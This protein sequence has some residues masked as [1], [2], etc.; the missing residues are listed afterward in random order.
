MPRPKRSRVASRPAP[1]SSTTPPPT[2]KPVKPARQ[3]SRAASSD[4]YDVSDREMERTKKR[5]EVNLSVLD[6]QDG[7][8]HVQPADS[9]Q[10]RTLEAARSREKDALGKLDNLT[11]T[12]AA[13]ENEPSPH[14]EY[15]R[16]ESASMAVGSRPPRLTDASGLDLDDDVF[17]NLDDSLDDSRDDTHMAHTSRATDTSSFNIAMFRRR[18]RQ[19]S[20][21][22]KDDAP[23]RPS[24]R[25]GN[26]PSA[27]S[28]LNL[29]RFKRRQREPSILGTAQKERAQ[30]PPSRASDYGSMMGDD[31]GPEGESTPLDK[32]R[33]SGRQDGIEVERSPSLP[34]RKRKSLEDQGG[35]EKRIALAVD[36]GDEEDVI[37]QSIEVQST[38]P[39]SPSLLRNAQNLLSTPDRD[40]PFNAPPAS[41]SSAGS[42]PVALPS[43]ELLTHRNYHAK[44]PVARAPAKTPE[45]EADNDSDLSSPPSLTHSPNYGPTR[46]STRTKAKRKPAADAAPPKPVKLTTADLTAL[47]PRRRQKNK[48]ATRPSN[49]PFDMDSAEDDDEVNADDDELSYVATTKRRR[50]G[51]ATLAQTAATNRGAKAKKAAAAAVVAAAAE[52]KK[53]VRK[54][55]LSSDK[56]NAEGEEEEE[57]EREGV[58]LGSV[59]GDEEEEDPETSQMMVERMGEELKRAARKFQEVDQWELSFEEVAPSSDGVMP[60][61]GEGEGASQAEVASQVEVAV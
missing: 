61:E 43:W 5:V 15:S 50:R 11:S 24:S 57:E 54:Y 22:G 17:G 3:I 19:S 56:E 37:Q 30:R 42:S 33:Q 1:Q 49:D 13:N 6:E 47:L 46:A 16:R 29:G 32:K 41:S 18:P 7:R 26:T 10:A 36:G 39:G 59:L 34:S 28:H 27:T 52:K 55:G 23:I 38:P 35:R 12:S 60:P 8:S 9:E 31:S 20:I 14:I 53:Q 4:I 2:S 51:A 44:K 58:T 48:K 40:D 45:L 21:V 25:G